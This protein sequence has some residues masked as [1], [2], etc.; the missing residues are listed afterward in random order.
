[1]PRMSLYINGRHEVDYAASGVDDET[2]REDFIELM[3]SYAEDFD[4][5]VF[6]E[7]DVTKGVNGW[8]WSHPDYGVWTFED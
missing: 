4:E 2:L 8:Q 1:M 5:P 7:E 6:R 3:E